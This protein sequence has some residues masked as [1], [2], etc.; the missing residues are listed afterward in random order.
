MIS[1]F[2]LKFPWHNFTFI[3]IASRLKNPRIAGFFMSKLY[4]T[5]SGLVFQVV[6]RFFLLSE[7]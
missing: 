3:L 5:L 6:L 7:A 1:V 4:L 2:A